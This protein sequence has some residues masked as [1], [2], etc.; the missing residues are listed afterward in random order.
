MTKLKRQFNEEEANA[1]KNEMFLIRGYQFTDNPYAVI[2]DLS[3]EDAQRVSEETFPNRNNDYLSVRRNVTSWLRS[4]AEESGVRIDKEN[5][6][7]FAVVLGKNNLDEI[8]NMLGPQDNMVVFKFK[9]VDITNW[10][11]TVDDAFI[12]APKGLKGSYNDACHPE[13]D[14]HGQVL[15]AE[16]LIYHLTTG[17]RLEGKT[18]DTHRYYEA[19][20]WGKEPTLLKNSV[21]PQL[22]TENFEH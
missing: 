3:D 16:S 7:S 14:L 13:D 15:N 18:H 6:V 9:D 22:Y 4:K 17:H 10:S 1:L 20:L 12:G 19:Q 11:F 5:P 8:L 21:E 2:D